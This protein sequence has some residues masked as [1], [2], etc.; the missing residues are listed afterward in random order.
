M[1][2]NITVG[3]HPVRCKGSEVTSLLIETTALG[4]LSEFFVSVPPH[5][6]SPAFYP[7]CMDFYG[8]FHTYVDLEKAGAR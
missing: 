6:T 7:N 3:M 1:S 4:I 8:L 5:G 2:F